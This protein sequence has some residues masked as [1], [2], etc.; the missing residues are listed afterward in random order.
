MARTGARR[1][2]RALRQGRAWQ[3]GRRPLRPTRSRQSLPHQSRTSAEAA[4]GAAHLE[5][6]PRRRD[7]QRGRLQ[8][9]GGQ[10]RRTACSA[11][12]SSTPTSGRRRSRARRATGCASPSRRSGAGTSSWCSTASPSRP[13]AARTPPPARRSSEAAAG[14]SACV[15]RL[16]LVLGSLS[17]ASRIHTQYSLT[18]ALSR[19]PPPALSARSSAARRHLCGVEKIIQTAAGSRLVHRRVGNAGTPPPGAA[20]GGGGPRW[21]RSDRRRAIEGARPLHRPIRRGFPA[22]RRFRAGE[23]PRSASFSRAIF[24]SCFRRLI[25]AP[26]ALGLRGSRLRGTPGP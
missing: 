16:V 19:A 9:L 21:L 15:V 7:H 20:R 24:S 26:P 22:H 18:E 17:G 12:K 10:G 3:E 5:G 13:R 25:A 14:G 4:G 8:V 2:R 11:G 6:D 23:A 1:S